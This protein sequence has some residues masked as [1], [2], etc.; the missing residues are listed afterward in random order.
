MNI[1]KYYNLKDTLETFSFEKNFKSLSNTLYYF[2]F[3]GNIFLV[4]LSFF[5]IKDITTTIPE[6]FPHQDIFF[7]IFII[8]FMSGYELFKRFA[9]E[10]LTTSLLK[11]KKVTYN[12][13]VGILVC[14]VLVI[15]SFYLALNGAHRLVDNTVVIENVSE[16]KQNEEID[17]TFTYYESQIKF[18]QSQIKKLYE[19]DK[20]GVL[21]PRAKASEI[22]FQ[23]K[24]KDKDEKMEKE[25]DKI[26][27][28]F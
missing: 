15:G 25:K 13:L 6:I 23:Q 12:I 11:I 9:F 18:N 14:L 26:W 22:E 8:L 27:K 10:Q 16:N 28:F 21:G 5:F 7:S 20:D 4:L 17:S 3:L 19:F 1:E 2:S 24:V